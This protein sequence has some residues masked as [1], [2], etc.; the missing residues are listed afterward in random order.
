M[1]ALRIQKLKIDDCEEALISGYH[2]W[3]TGYGTV[4][5]GAAGRLEV[6]RRAYELYDGH[7]AQL[8]NDIGP[9][10]IFMSVGVNSR[11]ILN[12]ACRI[13]AC[14]EEARPLLAR[15]PDG[16]RLEAA[17]DDQLDAAAVL[18]AMLDEPEHLGLGKVT[19]VLHK[20]RPA[21]IPILDS[22]VAD[23]LWRNFP[24]RLRETSPPREVLVLFRD[25]LLA[26]VDDLK[27][28]QAILERQGFLLTTVRVLDALIWLGWRKRN[29]TVGYGT[30]MT[31]MWG[32]ESIP[33]AR[34]AAR[35]AWVTRD[36][37]LDTSAERTRTD[38]TG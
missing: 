38:A 17:T 7:P 11:V 36:R 2:D 14:A 30:P 32:A 9:T 13:L 28:I 24:W 3:G 12:D 37:E 18:I 27:T 16:A 31:N 22:V 29:G 19:K 21:F 26:R 4:L 23:F 35:D 6:A 34:Q 5:P 10:E 25:V 15:I 1:T 20:K 8:G 33:A